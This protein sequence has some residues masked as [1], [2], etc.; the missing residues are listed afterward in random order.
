M[1]G[2]ATNGLIAALH[3]VALDD[4]HH[5]FPPSTTPSPSSTRECCWSGPPSPL[6]FTNWRVGSPDDTMRSLN[7][8]VD[9]RH[10]DA[11]AV[12]REFIAT[13]SR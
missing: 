6:R 11:A 7:Y 2:D 1:A 13:L 9:V 8:E 10:R 12:A 4:D 3:L 5:Y